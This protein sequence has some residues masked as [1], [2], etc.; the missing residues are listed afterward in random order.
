MEYN[1]LNTINSCKSNWNAS[2]TKHNFI[3]GI[4]NILKYIFELYRNKSILHVNLRLEPSGVMR[5][6]GL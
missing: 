6:F 1:F 3:L 5:E 2:K 4:E